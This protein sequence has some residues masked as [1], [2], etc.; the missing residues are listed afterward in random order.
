MARV[1]ISSGHTA[2]NPGIIAN[3]LNEYELARKIAKYALKYIRLNGI[4]SLS[5]PPNLDLA[6][7]IEWINKTG[8]TKAT[9]DLAIE[10]H[11]NDGNKRGVEG[12]Y[13][14]NGNSPSLELTSYLVEAVC[15]E[16]SL[17]SQGVK[18]EFE[19][20]L[21]SI[22][23]VHEAN[24]HAS[25]L[26]CGYID[27]AEDSAFLK[28]EA[29]L[30]AIGKG[31][32]KG[33]LKFYNLDYREFPVPQAPQVPMVNQ[34]QPQ[35]PMTQGVMAGVP[36]Q[37]VQQY[38][39][40]GQ[41]MYQQ[42][43]Q[44]G[45]P[46][47][48]MQQNYGYAQG[49]PGYPG[50]T[51][52]QYNQYPQYPQANQIQ[53]QVPQQAQNQTQQA[54]VQAQVVPQAQAQV[55]A[56]AQ[57]QVQVKSEE[58]QSVQAQP[59]EEIKEKKSETTDEVFF[60]DDKLETQTD[61]F[62]ND[63]FDPDLDADDEIDDDDQIV[64]EDL[65]DLEEPENDNIDKDK[66]KENDEPSE[67]SDTDEDD[68]DEVEDEDDDGDLDLDEPIQIQNPVPTNS[69]KPV[70]A[71]SIPSI[72]QS[73][74]SPP[75]YGS[76]PVSS[77]GYAPLPSREERK[78]MVLA[79]YNKILGREPNESDLNYFLN[80][81][82]R[83]E[84]LIKKMMDSQEHLDLVNAQKEFKE[85]KEKHETT[86]KDLEQLKYEHEEQQKIIENMHESIEQKNIALSKMQIDIKELQ[87]KLEIKPMIKEKG[88]AK[89][90]KGTF[91]DKL[92]RAVSDVLE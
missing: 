16:T 44:Q 20:E 69:F 5:T 11:I 90:Y 86:Q 74:I 39:T 58:S 84:D 62:E 79:T 88:P 24:A 85:L 48:P 14:G 32:A 70:P 73:N 65:D 28:I 75:S 37:S 81:G 25:V 15:Q 91:T 54:Q 34:F 3:G 19:H 61:E 45:I 50:Q 64:E 23:F 57:P 92:F 43:P 68:E 51:Y 17:P 89:K 76:S 83:E 47:Y 9:N 12:W 66:D 38:P 36:V 13:E 71:T 41:P 18:S 87:R 29:N 35:P 77:S 21:G 55:Q 42:V 53:A 10:I 7:R 8:Y 26:E 78:K 33:I 49:Y 67:K 63:D 59:T 56:Q 46:Q 30:D 72:S 6:Q 60:K 52:Q 4:I 80:I 1:I 2:S 40:G 22:S 82:I 31:I 27:N